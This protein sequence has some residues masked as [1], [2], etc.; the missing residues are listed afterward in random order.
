MLMPEGTA[1]VRI[2]GLALFRLNPTSGKVRREPLA[3]QAR[4]RVNHVIVVGNRARR[5]PSPLLAVV[6]Q[7][8]VPPAT[9]QL[10]QQFPALA[11]KR[12]F[13]EL[14]LLS[15]RLAITAGRALRPGGRTDPPAGRALSHQ[16]RL[17]A[18]RVQ[19]RVVQPDLRIGGRRD[20]LV[21]PR[22]RAHYV[23]A[24][25][26]FAVQRRPEINRL[27]RHYPRPASLCMRLMSSSSS[28]SCCL[29]GNQ[30][31]GA[32]PLKTGLMRLS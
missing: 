24:Q 27:G 12:P 15:L 18:R 28:A 31:S 22:F 16:R 20:D 30:P 7:A 10:R 19:V 11:M 2:E 23:L 5:V 9:A 32:W 14:P 29:G 1:G 17:G 6:S 3:Q 21:K 8:V 13:Q 25:A 4:L 26:L